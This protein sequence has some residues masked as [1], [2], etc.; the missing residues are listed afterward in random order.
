MIRRPPR[1]TLF[2]YTTLFRSPGKGFFQIVTD[3]FEARRVINQGR[4]AVVLEIEISEPF[5][6][7]G[8]D[9]PTCDKAQIDRQLDEMYRLGVRSSLLLN[10]FEN[11]PAGARFDSGPVG[12]VINNGNRLSAGSYW[13]ARTCTGPLAD[14]TIFQGDPHSNAAI[15]SLLNAAGFPSGTAP[16]Y[17]PPPHC[18]TRGLTNLGRHVVR[19]MMDLG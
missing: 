3:P 17:P 2:P 18:N 12:V 13:S 11:P 7:I 10:K 5:D 8:W 14:N 6:C 4:M 19:R 9:E 1:S 16:A 15:D